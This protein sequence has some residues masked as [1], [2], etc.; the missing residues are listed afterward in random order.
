MQNKPVV[1]KEFLRRKT[2]TV[3]A[4]NNQNKEKEKSPNTSFVE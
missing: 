4:K 2:Q 3:L 1:K